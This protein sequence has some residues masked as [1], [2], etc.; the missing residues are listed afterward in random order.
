MTGFYCVQRFKRILV[1]AEWGTEDAFFEG[2]RGYRIG[3][4][5][6]MVKIIERYKS[7]GCGRRLIDENW[8]DWDISARRLVY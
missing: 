4:L 5:M 8:K 1:S 7:G 6:S 3:L 2:N